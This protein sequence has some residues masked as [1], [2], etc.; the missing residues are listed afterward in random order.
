MLPR[1]RPHTAS[2]MIRR[3]AVCEVFSSAVCRA[4][5]AASAGLE[6]E[7][8][9]GPTH[10][11]PPHDPHRPADPSPRT[12]RRQAP[13][14]AKATP[15]RPPECRTTTPD[16][17][18]QGQKLPVSG[19]AARQRPRLGTGDRA[20]HA[21]KPYRRLA[22]VNRRPLIGTLTDDAELRKTPSWPRGPPDAS[23]GA[24]GEPQRSSGA[25]R[26]LRRRGR[27]ASRP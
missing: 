24:A 17:D 20:S 19:R 25:G 8:R 21:R 22:A 4:S 6:G 11:P 7:T 13:Q 3:A 27:P 5:D 18:A 12:A 26:R 23:R 16:P 2:L 9:S 1:A 10:L 14:V 15:A